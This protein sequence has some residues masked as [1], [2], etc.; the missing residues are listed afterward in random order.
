MEKALPKY[1]PKKRVKREK[2]TE[3]GE[4]V[5]RRSS[6][7]RGIPPPPLS[8]DLD[9]SGSSSEEEEEYDQETN[10]KIDGTINKVK[11]YL[12]LSPSISK[13]KERVLFFPFH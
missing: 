5:P 10:E 6:R 2:E 8:T 11:V 3:V 9:D 12:Y 13:T 1:V 4:F 7:G